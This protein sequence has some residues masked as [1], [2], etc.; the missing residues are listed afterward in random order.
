MSKSFWERRR[1]GTKTRIEFYKLM[2]SFL[3][4]DIPVYEALTDMRKEADRVKIFPPIVL[5]SLMNAMRGKGHGEV[6]TIGEA[7]AEWVDPI[8]AALIEAGER[9]GKLPSGFKEAVILLETRSRISKKLV[10]ELRYPVGLVFMLFGLL[11]LFST[12]LLPLMDDILPRQRWPGFAKSFGWIAD[13]VTLINIV[14]ITFLVSF[15]GSFVATATQWTG[16]TRNKVDKYILPWSLYRILQAAMALNAISMMIGAGVPITDAIK[17]L[18]SVASPWQQ[19]HY[20]R[21]LS[22]LKTGSTESEGIVG[23]PGEEGLF[24]A[25]ISFFV[26]MYGGR[27]NLA[28][29]MKSLAAQATEAMEAKVSAQC[30]LIGNLLQFSVAGMAMIAW[31]SFMA[32]TLTISSPN[33]AMH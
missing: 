8:E 29:S 16:D 31:S 33:A 4:D 20:F 19:Y 12:Q 32:V 7:L 10:S 22:R 15:F 30:K 28:E 9:S 26:R 6:K 25:R 11:W 5:D 2:Q 13:N 18:L 1:F 21:M 17:K 14:G 27:T 23:R 24:D 3:N